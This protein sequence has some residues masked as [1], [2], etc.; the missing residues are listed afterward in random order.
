[1]RPTLIKITGLFATCAVIAATPA[2]ALDVNAFRAQHKLPPLSVS[3]MLAAAAYS[4]ASDMASRRSLDHN[5]FRQRMAGSMG[6]EN[7]AYG[8]ADEDC[9][10]RMWAKSAGHRRNMLMKGI[11]SYGIASAT[12]ADGRTYWVLE[13]GN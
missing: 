13:L 6:A 8:C 11:T 9:V 7:V 3:P 2:L 5:G 10:T 12:S 1:M 4:H